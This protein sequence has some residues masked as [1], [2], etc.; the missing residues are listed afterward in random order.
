[1]QHGPQTDIHLSYGSWSCVPNEGYDVL[2]R[3]FWC[4]DNYSKDVLERWTSKNKK[5]SVIVVGHP[6]VEYWK[7]NKEEYFD[8]NFILYSL[9]PNPITLQQ[10]FTPAIIRLIK[11]S[12]EKWFIRLHPRQLIELDKIKSFLQ[13]KNALQNVNIENATNDALPVLLSNAKKHITH[14]SG[15]ALEASYYGL[16]TILINEIGLKSFPNLIETNMATFIDYKEVDF[17][18]KMISELANEE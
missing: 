13:E 7:Q 11:E 12:H 4:W 1:M 9:Q 3:N 8:K 6:W 2:P 10:L 18:D 5:Y 15:C 16:K 17:Y 14:S